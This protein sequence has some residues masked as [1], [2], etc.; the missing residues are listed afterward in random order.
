LPKPFSPEALV[1]KIADTVDVTMTTK[2]PETQSIRL[3]ALP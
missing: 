1:R 3:S 2:M